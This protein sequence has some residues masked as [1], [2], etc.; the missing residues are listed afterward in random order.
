MRKSNIEILRIICMYII[1]IQHYL[2]RQGIVESF[3]VF[4]LNNN[5]GHFLR[6]LGYP[7][8]VAFVMISG[9]FMFGKGFN[10]N[11]IGAISVQTYFYTLLF[12]LLG[13]A[14]GMADL[15]MSV[16]SVLILL[17]S[18]GGYWYVP[19]YIGM[20][21][22]VPFFEQFFVKCSKKQF[23]VGLAILVLMYFVIPTCSYFTAFRE[24]QG[25]LTFIT[26]YLISGYIKRFIDDIKAKCNK[27]TLGIIFLI[28]WLCSYLTYPL[29]EM[30]GIDL[31]NK[32]VIGM[33]NI[34]SLLMGVTIFLLFYLIDLGTIKWV[35]I[36][37]GS[38]FAV[39][40]IHENPVF[41]DKLWEIVNREQ[42]Y[43]SNLFIPHL[44]IT[45]IVIFTVSIVFDLA[46]KKFYAVF[47]STKQY[48]KLCTVINER[49][50]GLEINE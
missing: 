15:K 34:F 41:R 6:C 31:F 27:L 26:I 25:T 29:G 9:F 4:N 28:T 16:V 1:V 22:V 47:L 49:I 17:F 24:D 11:R 7:A 18:S 45:S 2:S 35:N 40:L 20:C 23:Q 19:A 46:I 13:L 33:N 50:K 43:E 30:L 10:F 44:L 8:L 37:S 32:F 42:Y 36:I 3:S 14:M 12:L 38:T 5:I 21:L 39:Y 48:K